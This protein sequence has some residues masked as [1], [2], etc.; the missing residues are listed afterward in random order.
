MTVNRFTDLKAD[1]DVFATFEGDNIVLLQLLAKSMLGNY[2]RQFG[3]MTPLG[4]VRYVAE[5]AASTVSELNPVVVRQTSEEH[6][7]DRDFHRAAFAWRENRLLTSV[8]GRLKSRLDSGMSAADALLEC[9]DHL[10]S[11]AKAHVEHRM[12]SSFA[13]AL[14]GHGDPPEQ[15]ILRR[16]CDLF[17]LSRLE[18]DKGFFLEQGYFEPAKSK[19]V[20]NLTLKLCADLRLQAVPLVDAFGIPEKLLGAPIAR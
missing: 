7:L 6:L 5:R 19:A 2:K 11:A 3:H 17:A 18:A 12:L 16:V 14:E 1:S 10:V 20:R 8:A 13:D 15:R 4:L 9:Q